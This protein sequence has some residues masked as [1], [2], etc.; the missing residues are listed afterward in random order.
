MTEVLGWLAASLFPFSYL[1]K[2]PLHLVLVQM[3]AA[4]VWIAYGV[5]IGSKPV[6]G[7]NVVV[8]GCAGFSAFRFARR[9]AEGVRPGDGPGNGAG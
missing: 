6:I 3:C 5:A 8:V 4:S 7:A 9:G 1:C 2:K